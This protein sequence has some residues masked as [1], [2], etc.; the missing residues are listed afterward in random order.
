MSVRYSPIKS[1]NVT[2]EK[3]MIARIVN[4]IDFEPEDRSILDLNSDDPAENPGDISQNDLL[5]PKADDATIAVVNSVSENT[6]YA[7]DRH[8][9]TTPAG[10]DSGDDITP[11]VSELEQEAE[12]QSLIGDDDPVQ[13]DSML[14]VDDEQNVPAAVVEY[15]ESAAKD[16]DV[17][18]QVSQSLDVSLKKKRSKQDVIRDHL[19]YNAQFYNT[20]FYGEEYVKAISNMTA[21]DFLEYFFPNVTTHNFYT[22]LYTSLGGLGLDKSCY[23][24][25]KI[26]MPM[27]AGVSDPIG[28]PS[29]TTLQLEQRVK[30]YYDRSVNWFHADLSDDVEH[31]VYCLKLYSIMDSILRNP[32]FAA[33][34]LS[35]VHTDILTSWLPRVTDHYDRMKNC[36]EY[37]DEWYKQIQYLHDLCW[38]FLD[39]PYSDNVKAARISSFAIEMGVSLTGDPSDTGLLTKADCAAYLQSQLG[40]DSNH[41]MIPD[42]MECPVINKYSVRLAMDSINRIEREY[43]EYLKTY[44]ANVNRRYQEL[45]CTFSITPDHPFAKYADANVVDHMTFVLTEGDTAVSDSDGASDIGSASNKTDQPWYKRLDYTGTLYRDGSENK[46]MGPN[47]KPMQKPDWTQHYSIL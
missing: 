27:Q 15:N 42:L 32:N 7:P 1:A 34:T 12:D 35:Q 22:R 6:N 43:P 44:V 30:L 14:D 25:L 19:S 21:F 5:D 10:N 13:Q 2:S 20:A 47:T 4:K 8:Y 38:N 23:R 33:D 3:R 28:T 17:M 16:S 45:G 26:R 11:P 29:V 18:K 36:H 46:E 9:I 37:T 41:Y 31:N 39:N 24:G 40:F